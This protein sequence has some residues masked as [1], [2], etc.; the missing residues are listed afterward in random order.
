MLSFKVL[1]L[2]LGMMWSSVIAAG[3]PNEFKVVLPDSMAIPLT[4]A[5]AGLLA[6]SLAVG[7]IMWHFRGLMDRIDRIERHVNSCADEKKS[8][9]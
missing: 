8:G 9:E 1:A 7:K 3:V 5:A 2:S 4:L 6:S